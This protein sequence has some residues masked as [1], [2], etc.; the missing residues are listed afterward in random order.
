MTEF[1]L[2]QW[3]TKKAMNV[4]RIRKD[5][6]NHS[7][8]MSEFRQKNLSLSKLAAICAKEKHSSLGDCLA[9]YW[10]EGYDENVLLALYD[11]QPAYRYM[12]LDY[13]SVLAYS[14]VDVYEH[15]MHLQENGN[16]MISS[17]L[18]YIGFN[19]HV[20][21]MVHRRLLMLRNE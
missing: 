11:A 3:H 7:E 19:R 17:W 9:R 20:L 4:N 16:L 15:I 12:A 8:K 5:R 14:G 13:C 18:E 21:A 6:D 2:I 10:G 1:C